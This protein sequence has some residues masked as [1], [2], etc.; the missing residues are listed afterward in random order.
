M[1]WFREDA[2]LPDG[3]VGPVDFCALRKFA[4]NCDG[5]AIGIVSWLKSSRGNGVGYVGISAKY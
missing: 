1:R 4:A 2:A 5:E 3:E